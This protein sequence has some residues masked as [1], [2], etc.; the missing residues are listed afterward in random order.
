VTAQL[1]ALIP[2]LIGGIAFDVYCLRDLAQAELVLHLPP[3]VWAA[4]ICVSTPLGGMA[5]LTLGR[6]H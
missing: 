3:I 5:Y 1:A 4:F 6:P 2:L